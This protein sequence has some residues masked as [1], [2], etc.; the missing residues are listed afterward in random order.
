MAIGEAAESAMR[1]PPTALPIDAAGDV[2]SGGQVRMVTRGGI[3][4]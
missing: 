1:V 2:R 4:G 3:D